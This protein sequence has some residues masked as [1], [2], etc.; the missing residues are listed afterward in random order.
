M[1]HIFYRINNSIKCI[2]E[3]SKDKIN[4]IQI[5]NININ[6][7]ENNNKKIILDNIFQKE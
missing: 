7:L 6:I 4:L 1:N 3:I 5:T 2:L